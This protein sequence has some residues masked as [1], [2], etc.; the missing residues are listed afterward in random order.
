MSFLGSYLDAGSIVR[1][2]LQGDFERLRRKAFLKSFEATVYGQDDLEL[3][4]S[5]SS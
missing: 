4:M 3:S 5:E 1:D 2:N